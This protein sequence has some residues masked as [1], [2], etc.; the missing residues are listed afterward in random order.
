VI[1]HHSRR[2]VVHFAVTA[3]PTMAWVIQQLREA[4]PFGQQPSD[5]WIT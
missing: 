5:L 4:M 2:Q 3:H 1:L